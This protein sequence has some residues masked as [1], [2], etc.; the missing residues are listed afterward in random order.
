MFN[1]ESYSNESFAAL[2]QRLN[3]IIYEKHN[4]SFHSLCKPR[5]VLF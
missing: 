3:Q 1:G 2:I 4:P 5:P